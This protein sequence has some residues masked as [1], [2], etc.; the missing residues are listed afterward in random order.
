MSNS[1]SRRAEAV[2]ALMDGEIDEMELY[3]TLKEIEGD[4]DMRSQWHRYQLASSAMRKELP[5]TL[6]DLSES[7][8]AAIEQEGKPAG[9]THRWVKPLGRFAVAASV[10]AMAVLGVQQFNGT[11][12]GA[13]SAP[14]AVVDSAETDVA[15]VQLPSAFTMPQVPVRTVSAT[16][17]GV[18]QQPSRHLVLKNQAIPDKA[19]QEQVQRYLNELMLRHTENAALN[20]N[21]GMMPFARMPQ[22]QPE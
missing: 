22:K 21:Q 17:G 9:L 12:Q 7:I 2:S 10:T 4:S 11:Q 1:D 16:S 20:T 5:E 6:V 3:R 15:P 19:T 8:K 18:T 14:L 13:T